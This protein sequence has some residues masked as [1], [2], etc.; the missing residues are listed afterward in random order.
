MPVPTLQIPQLG[1]VSGGVDWTPLANLGKVYEQ[2]KNKRGLQ[3]A[4]AGGV[5][6][7]NPQSLAQLSARVMPY[8]PNMGM[9]LAQLSTNSANRQQDLARQASRDA[10]DKRRFE[11]QFDL[12]RRAAER[13]DQDKW[14]V[15]DFTD[16]NGNTTFVRYNT[17][18]GEMQPMNPQ[19]SSSIPQAAGISPST[20]FGKAFYKADAE[21]VGEYM[22]AGKSAQEGKATLDQIDLLRKEAFTGPIL[23]RAATAVGYPANQA[24]EA[25]TNQLSLDIASKMKGSLSDKDVA[26]I[27]SQVPNAATGGAA[28]DAATG[29]IRAGF[30]RTAQRA[31]F[32]R[33]WAEQNGNVNGADVAWNR[34]INENPMTVEDRTAVGGRRFNPNYN[35]DFT[36]YI[37]TREQPS[38]AYNPVGIVNNPSQG[39]LTGSPRPSQGN[40]ADTMLQQ[41]REAIQLGAPRDAVLS[42]L[43]S[44][45]IDPGSL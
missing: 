38:P 35:S 15:K 25:A 45:G 9:S 24:L 37:K 43:R 41:A 26:F 17:R 34:Y 8:D 19:G 6:T 21:R 33:T 31:A 16:A 11:L 42:R 3:E 5:D 20:P 29:L 30:E 2:A 23:G 40:G 1:A 28:G 10:E 14:G 44:A 18:T 13:A 32:Y 4:L 36:R 12:S 39:N 22:D 7:S 27:K